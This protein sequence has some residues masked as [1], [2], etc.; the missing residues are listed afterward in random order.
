[1]EQPV[2]L[3][4]DGDLARHSGGVLKMCSPYLKGTHC[5]S[6]AVPSG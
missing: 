3:S 2:Q 6:D 5:P 4:Q 1:M